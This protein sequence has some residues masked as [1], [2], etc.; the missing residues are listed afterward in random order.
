MFFLIEIC[1][2]L[3][4]MVQIMFFLVGIP[5]IGW[6]DSGIHFYHGTLWRIIEERN[7]RHNMPLHLTAELAEN[8]QQ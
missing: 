6:L 5:R 2:F 8:A 1:V 3:I 4:R 7:Q